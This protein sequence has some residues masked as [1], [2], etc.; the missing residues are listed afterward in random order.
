[1]V[2]AC[3]TA[4][5]YHPQFGASKTCLKVYQVVKG[6]ND[7]TSFV[8]YHKTE[9]ENPALALH[10]W[11][12]KILAGVGKCLRAYEIGKKKMLRK[13][14]TKTLNSP[15]NTIKT[16]G[17]RVFVTEVMDSFHMFKYAGK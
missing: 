16:I 10:G 11:D 15:V 7:Q 6:N 12:S 2:L 9:I 17:K 14:E 4:L 3:A 1:M 13:A 5:T 8:F